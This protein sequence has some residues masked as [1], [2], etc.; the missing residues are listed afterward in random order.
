MQIDNLAVPNRAAAIAFHFKQSLFIL[1]NSPCN[2]FVGIS[3]NGGSG[4]SNK[5]V[6]TRLVHAGTEITENTRIIF[7]KQFGRL[8]CFIDF[9]RLHQ[10]GN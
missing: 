3:R 1:V 2:H 6:R 9:P 5:I 4:V 10:T 8:T 7:P